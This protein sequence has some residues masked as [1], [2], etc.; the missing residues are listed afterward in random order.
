MP[1]FLAKRRNYRQKNGV[2]RNG[3]KTSPGA[4]YWEAMMCPHGY[5]GR[6]CGVGGFTLT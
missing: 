3:G 4:A 5:A 1:V 2:K 6:A